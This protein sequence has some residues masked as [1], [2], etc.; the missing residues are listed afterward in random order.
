MLPNFVVGLIASVSVGA[1]VYAKTMRQTGNNTKSA[2]T[3]AGVT[4]LITFIVIFII[5][6][7]LFH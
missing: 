1:W 5:I 6:T 2:L 4:G 3:T 7:T